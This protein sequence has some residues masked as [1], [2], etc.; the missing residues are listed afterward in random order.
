MG[1]IVAVKIAETQTP[2]DALYALGRDAAS[3]HLGTPRAQRPGQVRPRFPA[4]TKLSFPP[5]G[6][7]DRCRVLPHCGD[8]L[9]SKE[10]TQ[11]V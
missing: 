7:G 1:L 11:W 2:R 10:E 5:S 9:S 8:I 3:A 6:E 4:A